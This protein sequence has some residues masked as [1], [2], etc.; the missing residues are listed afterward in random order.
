MDIKLPNLTDIKKNM[1]I[2]V[3][4]EKAADDSDKVVDAL[5]KSASAVSGNS[6][7]TGGADM[8]DSD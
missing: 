3:A 1:M 5:L 8:T 4:D 7:G 6:G 2:P